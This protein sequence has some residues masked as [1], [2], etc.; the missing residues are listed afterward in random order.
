[1][2]T[3]KESKNNIT[4]AMKELEEALLNPKTKKNKIKKRKLPVKKNTIDDILILTDVIEASPYKNMD[5]RLITMK[6][7]IRNIIKSDIQDWI[8]VNM[9]SLINDAIK[10]SLHTI[11][12][13]KK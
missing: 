12:Y 6:K 1:M 11:I 5:Y 3:K 7:N 8:N 4:S 10:K 13:N 2:V 9:S